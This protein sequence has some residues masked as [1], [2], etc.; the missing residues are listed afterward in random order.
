MPRLR[1]GTVIVGYYA[2]KIR[3][4]LYAQNRELIKT[5]Q[6]GASEVARAAGELNQ[7]LYV[8]LV[9]RLVLSKGDI[10]RVEI[11]YDIVGDRVVWD[12]GSLRLN[13]YRR[14]DP[15]TVDAA[16]KAM[17]QEKLPVEA[18]G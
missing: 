17:R 15:D 4:I 14:V 6:L 11:N 13:V 1:T 12:L 10:V 16:L 7:R 5:G 3:K 18:G 8:A 9:E 2:Q